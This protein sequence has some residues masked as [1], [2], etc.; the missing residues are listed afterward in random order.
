MNVYERKTGKLVWQI[1]ETFGKNEQHKIY[2]K[3][4]I[5]KYQRDNVYRH[6]TEKDLYSPEFNTKLMS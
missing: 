1:D 2:T 5:G 6:L 3:Y 4:N